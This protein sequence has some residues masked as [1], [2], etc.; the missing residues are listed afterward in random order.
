MSRS[1]RA[2]SSTAWERASDPDFAGDYSYLFNFIEGGE[3]KLDGT[4]D[5]DLRR[6]RRRR[7]HDP[8]GHA[9]GAVRQLRRRWPASSCSCPMPEAAA[10]AAR[11]ADWE[12]GLMIGN[13]PYKLEAARTDQEIVLVQERRRGPATSTARPGT[14]ASTRSPSRSPPTPTPRT[15]RS[16]PARATTPTS[17]RAAGARPRRT[18]PTRSTSGPRHPV[19]RDQDGPPGRRWRRRTC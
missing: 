2:R 11:P 4:A 3:E 18:T 5:D 19:L 12:N 1:C 15:T 13:G 9:V 8:H 16:R 6:R 14:I 10:R 17:R 7:R